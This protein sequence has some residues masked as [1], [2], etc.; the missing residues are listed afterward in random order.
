MRM[1]RAYRYQNEDVDYPIIANTC[2]RQPGGI[3]YQVM[4]EDALKSWE[5]LDP[6]E[7]CRGAGFLYD[8]VETGWGSGVTRRGPSTRRTLFEELAGLLWL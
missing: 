1:P 8:D 5:Q 2:A 7:M 4:D 6:Q 3:R